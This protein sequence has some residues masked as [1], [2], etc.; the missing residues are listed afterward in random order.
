M[1]RLKSVF[2]GTLFSLSLAASLL[3]AVPVAAADAGS[4]SRVIVLTD[5][6]NEPD[7]SESMVRFLLYS[8]ELD[9]EGLLAVTS[10]WLRNAVHPELIEERVRAYGRVLP[11]LRVHA[12]GYPEAHTLLS[13]IKAGRPEYGMSGVGS[14]KDTD[15]SR[16]IINAADRDDPR[17][18]WLTLWG[19]STDLAQ[20]LW[21]VQSTRPPSDVA[22]FVAKLRVYSISDQ[23][24]AASWIRATFPTL[25][26]IVSTH[27]FGDYRLATWIGISAPLP[28]ADPVPITRQWLDTNI[29]KGPLGAFYPEPKYL[30]EG[31]T[32]S[33]LY[34]IP[35]GLGEPEHPSW[36]SWGGRY[37]RVGPYLGLWS[38]TTDQAKGI[39]GVE[40]TNNQASIWRWRRDF[41]NDF[42]A[43]VNWTITRDFNR[44]NHPPSTMVNGAPGLTPVQITSCANKQVKLS[45][46]GTQDP[47]SDK[48]A[49]HWWQY[50][51]ASG[52]VNPQEI[53]I[54]GSDSQEAEVTAPITAK[55]APNVDI[56]SEVTYHILLSVTDEGSPPL[57][58]YR[59]IL[60][61][62]PTNCPE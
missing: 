47:D 11:N 57:T 13:L 62:V 19:G 27:A 25:F 59:R 39:D 20:A 33:F 46:V 2:S 29:R 26:W 18:L 23:D 45:A 48:L 61:R 8:N 52:G 30:M 56:P 49:Y 44:A 17:P 36:G 15:A 6:G 41:Q 24:D 9:V 21:F 7:D 22:R 43:R 50:R 40:Y 38:D 31:D 4:K 10:T 1:N 37:G 32:P 55:P 51:E 58:R 42:A 3:L 12:N 28:G 53:A 16:L 54:N 60:L 34:L 35:N 14:G 5:I